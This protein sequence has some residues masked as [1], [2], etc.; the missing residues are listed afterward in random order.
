[1]KGTNT[2]E[3]AASSHSMTSQRESVLRLA[4]SETNFR[5]QS[6]ILNDVL[7]KWYGGEDEVADLVEVKRNGAG[8]QVVFKYSP[9]VFI[10]IMRLAVACYENRATYTKFEKQHYA[11]I[12]MGT[13]MFNLDHVGMI[14]GVPRTRVMMWGAQRP[15]SFP[16][17]R[18]GGFFELEAMPLMMAWWNLRVQQ[19][20]GDPDGWLLRRALATGMSVSTLARFAGMTVANTKKA[21]EEAEK[22]KEP[23]GDITININAGDHLGAPRESEPSVDGHP[24]DGGVDD[25]P[26]VGDLDGDE[27][28]SLLA[29][30]APVDAGLDA[31]APAVYLAPNDEA[32]G[33]DVGLA[34]THPDGL[35]EGDEGGDGERQERADRGVHPFFQ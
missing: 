4:L 3:A 15:E 26:V 21:V 11:H 33:G 6:P 19:P 29:P 5:K 14:L 12:L 20:N 13:C 32:D 30:P 17:T 16:M 22:N 1:M 8:K 7:L 2:M 10:E 34:D 24:E 9:S 28:G 23:V 31:F 18:L 25:D 35:H 27:G